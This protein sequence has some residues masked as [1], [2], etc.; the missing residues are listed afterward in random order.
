MNRILKYRKLGYFTRHASQ[1][2]GPVPIGWQFDELRKPKASYN[3]RELQQSTT[4]LF[5][6]NDLKT[7]Q[8]FHKLKEKAADDVVQLT[9]EVFTNP[10]RRKLVQIFDDISNTLCKVADLSEFVRTSHPD[11]RYRDAADD[12]FGAISEIVEQLNTNSDLY[13]LLNASLDTQSTHHPI[14]DECDKRVTKLYL[15]DFEQSGIHLDKNKRDSFV[16]VNNELIEVLMKFQV[17]SQMPA[18]VTLKNVDKKFAK[19]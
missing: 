1:A 11:R 2:H 5:G 6:I 13:K 9:G 8:G 19:M 10:S 4:G 16:R 14:L 12:A 15:V 17:N 3:H 7:F 18:E